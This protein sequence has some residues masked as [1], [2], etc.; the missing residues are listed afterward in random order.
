MHFEDVLKKMLGR[1]HWSVLKRGG[2]GVL[3]RGGQEQ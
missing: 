3:K 2:Q 1:G